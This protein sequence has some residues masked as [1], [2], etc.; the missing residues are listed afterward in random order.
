MVI[1]DGRRIQNFFTVN[2]IELDGKLCLLGVGTDITEERK[3]V[4]EGLSEHYR[5]LQETA[6]RLEQSKGICC[7]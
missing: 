1:K 2:R 7:N 3:R 4:E 5:E 6:E